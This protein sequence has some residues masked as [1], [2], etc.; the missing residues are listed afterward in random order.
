LVIIFFSE[1]F[2]VDSNDKDVWRSNLD[3]TARIKLGSV[4]RLTLGSNIFGIAIN[5]DGKIYIGAWERGQ[6]VAFTGENQEQ[7][8]LE[9]V[10]PY[11]IGTGLF[12]MAYYGKRNIQPSGTSQSV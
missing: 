8:R 4:S 11:R 5:P 10:M 2:W 6:V 1:L 7:I 12:S 3:G 9:S